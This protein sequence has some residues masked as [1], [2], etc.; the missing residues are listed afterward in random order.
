MNKF[1]TFFLLVYSS[2]AVAET[3]PR[4]NE[5]IDF[6]SHR[7]PLSGTL[8]CS[9]GFTYVELDSEYIFSIIPLIADLDFI[10]PDYFEEGKVGA[11]ITVIYPDEMKLFG[12]ESIDE[13][14]EAIP[15]KL[16]ECQIVYPKRNF[17]SAYLIIVESSRLD[18][19]REK[20]GLGKREY[21]FHITVGIK[22]AAAKE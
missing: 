5:V 2:L 17:E 20:Y 18:Q 4:S 12:I 11:H 8:K 6:V 7:L 21:P 19:I 13:L 9:S 22:P 16:E 3:A 14:D 1:L 15:F 10:T